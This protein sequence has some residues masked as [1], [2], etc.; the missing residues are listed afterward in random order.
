VTATPF[1]ASTR[2]AFPVPAPISR[3]VPTGRPA[4]ASTWPT[5][6]SGYPGRNRSYAAAT[7]PKLRARWDTHADHVIAESIA[8]HRHLVDRRA[9]WRRKDAA[10]QRRASCPLGRVTVV[11]ARSARRRRS[12]SQSGSTTP[13]EAWGWPPP[14]SRPG[15]PT[16]GP[17]RPSLQRTRQCAAMR[18]IDT[19]RRDRGTRDFA[20]D[21]ACWNALGSQVLERP[22]SDRLGEGQ[23]QRP[24]GRSWH[25]RASANTR[26]KE[27][28]LL[29][30]SKV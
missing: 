7:A 8:S 2:V 22:C 5:S 9:G 30:T 24:S 15:D 28:L 18:P 1:Q 27:H 4:Y 6:S 20:D 14:S 13:N 17:D 10:G 3:A 21:R 25:G 16:P 29:A 23:L 19:G 12:S 11:S 26:G